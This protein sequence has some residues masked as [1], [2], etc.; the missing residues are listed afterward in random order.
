MS[1][2]KVFTKES[3]KSELLGIAEAGWW[4][5]TK[6]HNAGS[7]GNLLEELLGIE[8]NNLPLPNASEWEL[9]A[10]RMNSKSLVTLKHLSPSPRALK[11]VPTVLLPNYG[12]Q[13][14]Q[15]GKK[16]PESEMSFRQ[17][18]TAGR[19]TDRGFTLVID[20]AAR[21]IRVSF[22]QT[23]VDLVKHG[24]WLATVQQRVGNLNDLATAPY[25][26]FDDLHRALAAK[27][28]NAFFVGAKSSKNDAGAE[29]LWY[30]KAE[31][32]SGLN[33]QRFLSALRSGAA[34]VDF[35]ARTGHD[36]GTKFRIRDDSLVSLYANRTS[37]FDFSSMSSPSGL[38][39]KE[40][41]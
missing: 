39:L 13:H 26:G 22:D 32:V 1:S 28:N 33:F 19:H 27:L 40:T 12:W 30:V 4:E 6:V 24:A 15:A 8:E 17:T 25:W 38:P 21:H 10:R 16:Y 20:H 35:D 14:S 5:N 34:K 29:M 9:K 11:L 37:L 3:L 36:H 31:M 41:T 2:P 18:L 7:V 23:K